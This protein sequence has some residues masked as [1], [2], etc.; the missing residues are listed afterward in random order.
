MSINICARCHNRFDDGFLVSSGESVDGVWYCF[1]C[2]RAVRNEKSE[3]Y[4]RERERE[5]AQRNHEAQER[6]QRLE[7]EREYEENLAR[8]EKFE[9]QRREDEERHRQE[10]MEMEERHHQEILDLT[11]PWYNCSFCGKKEREDR[12]REE[13]GNKF[14]AECGEKIRTCQ[15]CNKKYVMEKGMKVLYT[16]EDGFQ[17]VKNKVSYKEIYGCTVNND[18]FACAWS[19]SYASSEKK[20]GDQYD[21]IRKTRLYMCPSCYERDQSGFSEK[22]K[23]RWEISRSL[24]P[25]YLKLKERKEREDKEEEERKEREAEKRR[26]EEIRRKQL[27]EQRAEEQ[28]LAKKKKD[29]KNYFGGCFGIILLFAALIILGYQQQV[30]WGIAAGVGIALAVVSF[31][32]RSLTSKLFAGLFVAI[33]FDAVIGSVI[34]LIC[35]FIWD[36]FLIPLAICFVV[37]FILGTILYAAGCFDKK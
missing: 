5:R 37:F 35:Y 28:A 22:N 20:C 9:E 17:S 26:Q 21:N 12:I 29:E 7:R 4:K 13:D 6:Q 23:E 36:A 3:E 27:A 10:M 1:N 25:E 24:K 2:A 30:G 16:R 19:I 18:P 8:Q 11:L 33:I 34:S 15:F 14:C 31:L 32:L